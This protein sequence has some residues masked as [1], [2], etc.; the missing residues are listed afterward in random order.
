M[1]PE[2]R[3]CASLRHFPTMLERWRGGRVQLWNYTI[4]HRVLTLRIE[5]VGVRGNLQIGCAELNYIRAPEHWDDCDIEIDLIDDDSQFP[6]FVV[7]D[8]T[9]DVEIICGVAE[10]RENV[11]PIYEPQA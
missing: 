5:R 9:A 7:R 6:A 2:E 4:S 11:K 8:R 10:I 3:H 1:T